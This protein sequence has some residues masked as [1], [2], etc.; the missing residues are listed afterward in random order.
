[1]G[2]AYHSVKEFR[3]H[4]LSRFDKTLERD[5]HQ[6]CTAQVNRLVRCV[7]LSTRSHPSECLTLVAIRRVW[8]SLQPFFWLLRETVMQS[9]INLSNH[10]N[11]LSSWKRLPRLAPTRESFEQHPDT[12]QINDMSKAI[13]VIQMVCIY[14]A[15]TH[16]HTLIHDKTITLDN[17]R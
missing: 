16:E 8:T 7:L 11:I 6:L 4:I 13:H 9:V 12:L 17:V 5:G 15:N 10:S 2:T 14:V 1:M 3:Q